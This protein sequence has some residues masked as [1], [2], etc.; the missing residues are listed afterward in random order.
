MRFDGVTGLIQFDGKGKRMG[1]V[2]LTEIKNGIPVDT[3]RKLKDE[4]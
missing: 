3:G 4:N 1:P 2:L